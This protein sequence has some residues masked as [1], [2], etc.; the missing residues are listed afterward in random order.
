MSV[1][2]SLRSP[3]PYLSCLPVFSD[4]DPFPTLFSFRHGL[5]NKESYESTRLN[6]GAGCILLL[7]VDSRPGSFEV[8][9]NPP[10]LFLTTKTSP[11]SSHPTESSLDSVVRRCGEESAELDSRGEGMDFQTRLV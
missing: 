1:Y 10:N 5:S 3:G 11:P 6:S 9:R 7:T 2:Y 8:P 4:S